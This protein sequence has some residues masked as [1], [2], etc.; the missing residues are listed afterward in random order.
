MTC[1]PPALLRTP[2]R[3][4]PG[5]SPFILCSGFIGA[6]Y[7][8]IRDNPQGHG[9]SACVTVSYSNYIFEIY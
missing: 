5:M 2:G 1:V 9:M 8:A 6:E 7:D 4:H 3:S